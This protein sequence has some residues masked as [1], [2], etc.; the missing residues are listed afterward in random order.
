MALLSRSLRR[1]LDLTDR[2]RVREI[3]RLHSQRRVR[4][5]CPIIQQPTEPAVAGAV[6]TLAQLC[7]V[8]G[9]RDLAAL[10]GHVRCEMREVLLAD[11]NGFHRSA[12]DRATI[13]TEERIVDA[14]ASLMLLWQLRWTPPAK[15]SVSV[16]NGPKP[17]S[18]CNVVASS[19]WPYP[20]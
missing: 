11:S 15:H 1:Q 13:N 4:Y 18:S 5:Q 9:N 12:I 7:G 10:R 6:A 17:E 19:P 20:G 16:P 2:R 14:L 3:G 8:A